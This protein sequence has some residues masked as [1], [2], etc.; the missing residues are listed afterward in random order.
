MTAVVQRAERAG[1]QVRPLIVPTNN[2]LH[3]VLQTAKDLQAHEL[4]VGASN[5]YT[6]DEQLEQIAF[7]WISLHDGQPA[8]LTV[9]VLGRDRDMYLD[10]AGGN[11]IP[12]ISERRARSV[13]ELRAAGVGVDRVLLLHDGSPANSD[14]FQGVL[15]MLDPEV[16][17]GIVPVVP[18]GSDPLNGHSVVHQDQERARQLGR[19]L[20]V[21]DLKS[22]DGPAIVQRAREDQYDLIILPMPDES[23]VDSVLP[24]DPRTR[25]VITHA[26]CRVFLATAPV[27]PQEVVDTTPSGP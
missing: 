25:H 11:R 10:L 9:R 16:V 17:L 12:K 19:A 7:Y 5:K 26:H 4:I 13:A 3:A 1:K 2:P 27:I 15:T 8:P 6:A 23:A 24:L 20:S 22:A 18:P 14:L 21:L